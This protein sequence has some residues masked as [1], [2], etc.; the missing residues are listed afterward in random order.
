MKPITENIIKES[1][2]ETQIKIAWQKRNIQ[3]R[4]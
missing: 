1:A 2:I 3:Q 4:N